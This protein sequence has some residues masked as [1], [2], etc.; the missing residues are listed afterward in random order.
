[1]EDKE[2]PDKVSSHVKVRPPVAS[3]TYLRR[4]ESYQLEKNQTERSFDVQEDSDMAS[5]RMLDS[6]NKKY[7]NK[8]MIQGTLEPYVNVTFTENK[9][10]QQDTTVTIERKLYVTEN[11]NENSVCLRRN[12]ETR[13]E[14]KRSPVP[15][16][17]SSLQEKNMVVVDENNSFRKNIS[18]KLIH[19]YTTDHIFMNDLNAIAY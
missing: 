16:P 8:P 12:S 4:I 11:V 9:L 2:Q 1:M 15:T 19:V 14:G 3:K 17:R 6:L 13:L 18:G 7:T 5:N 10:R